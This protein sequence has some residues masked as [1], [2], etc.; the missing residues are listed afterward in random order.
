MVSIRSA[1]V[2]V[3]SAKMRS[4][5]CLL[6]DFLECAHQGIHILTCLVV[7]HL[8]FQTLAPRVLSLLVLC[9]TILCTKL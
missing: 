4:M 8:Y 1:V 3:L 7:L 9:L 2:A 6:A 5:S